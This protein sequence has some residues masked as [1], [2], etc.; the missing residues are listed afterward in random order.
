MRVT[1]GTNPV[2][3][4]GIFYINDSLSNQRIKIIMLTE[5]KDKI[6]EGCYAFRLGE[7]NGVSVTKINPANKN[8]LY[9]ALKSILSNCYPMTYDLESTV[10]EGNTFELDGLNIP[11]HAIDNYREKTKV[12]MKNNFDAQQYHNPIN[13]EVISNTEDSPITQDIVEEVDSIEK[14]LEDFDK[15]ENELSTLK[16]RIIKFQNIKTS[17]AINYQQYNTEVEDVYKKVA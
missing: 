12:Y 4:E 15:I 3:V 16:S 6:N 9:Q 1:I 5:S 10:L 13:N 7:L 2:N 14:L 11:V 8:A 17:Q